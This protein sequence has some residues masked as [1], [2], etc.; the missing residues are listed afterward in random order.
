VTH[1]NNRAESR[2]AAEEAA[3]RTNHSFHKSRSR[4][5]RN[6]RRRSGRR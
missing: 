6:I 1:L 5:G 4:E 3:G 2:C